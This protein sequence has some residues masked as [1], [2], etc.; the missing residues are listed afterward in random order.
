VLRQGNDVGDQYRSA[1][2]YHNEAQKQL[3]EASRDAQQQ[4]YTKPIATQIVPASRFYSAEEYHQQ[5]LQ[6]V[7]FVIL[8]FQCRR[9]GRICSLRA[10][11]EDSPLR[12]GAQI[13]LHA[14]DSDKYACED[15]FGSSPIVL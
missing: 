7:R 6:K 9:A 3:A 4:H 1:I 2:F 15:S 8:Y 5:Y 12:K 11:R 10:Y 14:T 13:Q